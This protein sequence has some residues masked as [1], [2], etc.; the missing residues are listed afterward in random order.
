MVM[1]LFLVA[2]DMCGKLSIGDLR[3]G[4]SCSKVKA[5]VAQNVL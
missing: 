3:H 1:W 5:T 4:N 2:C